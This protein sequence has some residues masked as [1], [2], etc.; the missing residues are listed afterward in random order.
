MFVLLLTYIKPLEE[1]NKWLDDHK[2]YI[3]KNY[4]RSLFIVSGRRIPPL[5]GIILAHGASK[6]EIEAVVAEDPYVHAGV[7]EYQILEFN[8][9]SSDALFK[10]FLTQE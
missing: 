8:P 7:A 6:A 5:G 2:R 1:V 9:T 3:Q 4:E 10:P